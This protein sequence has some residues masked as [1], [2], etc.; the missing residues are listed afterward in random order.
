MPQQKQLVWSQLRVGLLTI[1]SLILLTIAI[2]L[3]SG[4][5]GGFFSRKITVRTLAPDAGGLKSGAPVRLAGI[6]VGSVKGVRISGSPEPA[7]AVEI[8]MEVAR[9]YRPEIKTDSEAFLAAEGLLGE[10]YINISKGTPTSPEIVEGATIPFHATAEFSELVGGS[11]DLLDNLNVLTSRLNTVVGKIESGEGTVGRLLMDDS[12]Y[13]R[14][15][16]TVNEVQKF[17]N[18]L[19]NNQGSLGLLLSS[20]ELYRH[21]DQTLLKLQTMTDQLQN[22]K[23][24]VAKLINDPSLYNKANDLVSRGTVLVDNINQGRGTL[25][26]LAR[27][28]E[29]YRKLNTAIDNLN[30]VISSIQNSK[31]SI[32]RLIHDPALYDNLNST[33]L[34]VR[35][36][37]ADFR[38]NP[39][40][41]LTIRFRIF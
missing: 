41:F 7:Q 6:D 32:G 22:G 23:G 9:D 24:T 12:L 8:V 33:S 29:M 20:D 19:T 21:L 28:E 40:K 35:G 36:L 1:A 34:E 13:Q 10:R 16:V 38:H 39:K 30:N 2:F 18:Q 26:K 15:D 11:R 25:G 14:I 17:A 27:D 3:V 5:T 31:G 37:L 4:Q